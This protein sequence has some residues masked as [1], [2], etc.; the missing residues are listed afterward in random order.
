[1]Q[2][3]GK[4]GSLK[5]G[6]TANVTVL[7]QNPLTV[8]PEKIKDIEVLATVHEGRILPVKVGQYKSVSMGKQ[9]AVYWDLIWFKLFGR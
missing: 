6:K 4:I 5:A 8:S 2:L 9:M 1:M 3:E 7:K